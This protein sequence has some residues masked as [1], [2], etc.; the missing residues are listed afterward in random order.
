M[1]TQK[2]PSER[3][4]EQLEDALRVTI[5]IYARKGIDLRKAVLD[6]AHRVRAKVS[7]QG[8]D[9]EF[10]QLLRY[11]CGEVGLAACVLVARFVDSLVAAGVSI[12]GPK[13]QRARLQRDL[14]H[15]ATHLEGISRSLIDESMWEQLPGGL[16]S[17]NKTATTL[18]KYAAAI[19][20]FSELMVLGNL[21]ST[22]DLQRFVFCRYVQL[23]TKSWHDK[24]VSAILQAITGS[25]LAE[26]TLRMWRSRSFNRLANSNPLV[27]E[28]LVGIADFF[29]DGHNNSE[30]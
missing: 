1:V 9:V 10:E 23:K 12:V 28:P 14:L 11:G 17:P 4:A 18:R 2:E 22:E 24:E 25:A 30:K 19:D 13:D 20:S 3:I 7:A 29:G 8:A 15:M 6:W 5:E 16:E 21:R 27:V 26:T